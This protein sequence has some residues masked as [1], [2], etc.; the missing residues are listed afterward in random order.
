SLNS[1]RVNLG[2]QMG[3]E[4]APSKWGVVVRFLLLCWCG[5]PM[6]ATAVDVSSTPSSTEHRGPGLKRSPLSALHLPAKATLDLAR[7][8][9][10]GFAAALDKNPTRIFEFVRDQ[11]R[12]EAYNGCLRG[13]RGTLLAMSG[14]SVD[15]A[16][17]LASLLRGVRQRVR[18][19][20][21]MLPEAAAGTLVRSIWADETTAPK[22]P[23]EPRAETKS[24]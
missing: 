14:N 21:G 22:T 24:I 1:N 11:I 19:A 3:S 16:T 2:Q 17:L 23:R 6:A 15:R 4:I 12:Y 8:D 13:P 7:V 20:R 18:F 9:P 5:L 10:A